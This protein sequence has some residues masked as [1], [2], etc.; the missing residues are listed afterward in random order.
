MS[1]LDLTSAGSTAMLQGLLAKADLTTSPS[2]IDIYATT[3]PATP[4]DAAG[5]SPLVTIVLTDPCGSVVSGVLSL[6]QADST[7]DLI[8]SSGV[9][10]WARWKA[11]DGSPLAD[12]MVTDS[13]GAGPFKMGG[14][15]G[16]NLY[17]GGR[18][19]L[20]SVALT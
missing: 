10:V 17:A 1:T 19:V 8:S 13:A 6:T 4:G 9:A 11:G 14:T 20:G 5:G 15:T 2:T 16:T 7:G 12:G 18:A 3:K